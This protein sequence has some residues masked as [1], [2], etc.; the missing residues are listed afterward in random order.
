M[1]TFLLKFVLLIAVLGGIGFALW[2]YQPWK[3]LKNAAPAGSESSESSESAELNPRS[4]EKSAVSPE[5][6]TGDD[7]KQNTEE[8]GSLQIE[9]KPVETDETTGE[10]SDEK[11][12]QKTEKS[13]AKPEP[14]AE[15]N[16]EIPNGYRLWTDENGNRI[17]AKFIK[18]QLG[19]AY[20]QEYKTEEMVKIPLKVLTDADKEYLKPLIKKRRDSK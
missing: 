18:Y 4:D 9:K 1:I 11:S 13:E 17:V 14:E 2:F 5:K 6:A 10:K 8:S 3:L 15:T 19:I 12:D 16:V 20:V 7:S